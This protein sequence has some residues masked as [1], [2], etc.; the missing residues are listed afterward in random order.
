MSDVLKKPVHVALL[1]PTQL[2]KL[3][4]EGHLHQTQFGVDPAPPKQPLPVEH[5]EKPYK[6]DLPK[7]PGYAKAMKKQVQLKV[8]HS[9]VPPVPPELQPPCG[10]C[11]T[12]ACCHVFVVN[13]D[14]LEYESGI[15]GDAAIKLTPEMYQQLRGRFILAQMLTA[16]RV[17]KKPGYYLEGKIGEPCPFLTQDN[18]CGIYDIRPKTCRVYTCVGDPRITEGMRQGI[19]PI[20]A[21]SV[22]TRNRDTKD[23]SN[24]E[25]S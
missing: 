6:V 5:K 7:A 10:T 15:Y 3:T 24:N 21:V 9:N 12:A 19:E 1:R 2:E 14:E 16:P 8:I 11:K 17:S 4:A 22:L 25:D 13:I 23:D 20:D 18:K